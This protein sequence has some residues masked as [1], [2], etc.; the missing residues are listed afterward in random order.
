MEQKINTLDSEI[1]KILKDLETC[2]AIIDIGYRVY[3]IYFMI[4][5]KANM[6]FLLF[7][8]FGFVFCF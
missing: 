1:L 4:F 7:V 6:F 3:L 8:C 2:G 5:V